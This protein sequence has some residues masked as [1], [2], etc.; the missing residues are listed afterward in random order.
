MQSLIHEMRN[1]IAIAVANVEAF[2]D[3]KLEP[4]PKRL[5]S[6]LRALN[7]LDG[8][9]GDVVANGTSDSSSSPYES[10]I[11]GIIDAEVAGIEAM[12]AQRDISL[13]IRRCE[14]RE[15]CRT[16]SA[17]PIRIGQAVRN[18]LLNA[19]RYSPAGGTLSVSCE[20]TPGNLALTIAND[21][22]GIAPHD[23]ARIF[24][25]TFRGSLTQETLGSGIGLA[26]AK[27]IF[28]DHGGSIAASSKPGEGATFTLRLPI[29]APA[30]IASA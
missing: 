14:R 1:H 2:L 23:L 4:S 10:D 7:E 27:K 21:G 18:V 17:D 28:D 12:V 11:C 13:V 3:G 5:Q 22:V 9:L 24:D 25:M 6:V 16:L 20:R 29:A 8:L 30:P 15:S 26:V 19:V